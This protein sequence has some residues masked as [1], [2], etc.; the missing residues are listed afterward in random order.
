MLVLHAVG[1]FWL[2]RTQAWLYQQIASLPPAIESH[3]ACHTTVHLDEFPFPR[4]HARSD[5]RLPGAWHRF[6]QRA[7][8]HRQVGWSASVARQ[9]RPTI[10]HSHFGSMGW[11]MVPAV[12]WTG[13]RHVVTFYGLD[14]NYLP[15]VGWRRRY[16]ELFASVD[17]VLCEGPHM[18]QCLIALGCPADK[19]VVHRLGVDLARIPF[20]PRVWQPGQPLRVLMAA[21]FREKKGLPFGL[22]A[23]GRIREQVPLRIDIVG[24]PGTGIEGQ[25]EAQR[26]ERAIDEAGLRAITTMRGFLSHAALHELAR[27]Q[28]LFLAPSVTAGNGDTE[29]GAPVTVIEMAASGMLVIG[30]RHC[31]IPDIV[32]DGVTG[33]LADERC[34]EGLAWC[35]RR[36]SA[37]PQDWAAMQAAA[38]ARIGERHD[39][40]SQAGRLAEHYRELAAAPLTALPAGVARAGG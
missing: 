34:V 25:F 11:E 30:S 13:A 15:R 20:A 16:G 27:E 38:R 31:D 8:L 32:E 39:A 24:G 22:A 29:G 17:R 35:L 33:W 12:K 26:I 28:H 23:L 5:S 19:V 36:A 2:E 7:R 37:R 40:L 9:L 4:I 21:S 10:V 3:V 6:V 18:R 14:V 1:E